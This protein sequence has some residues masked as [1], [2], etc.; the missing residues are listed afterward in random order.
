MEPCH[1]EARNR[2]YRTIVDRP[3]HTR[4]CEIIV[5]GARR[6]GAPTDGVAL[7]VGEDARRRTREHPL[8]ECG[9]IAG[10]LSLL[11]RSAR[12]PSRHVPAASTPAA[13]SEQRL[14]IHPPV[15]REPAKVERTVSGAR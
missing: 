11:I 1:E 12:K 10:A 5:F 15:A 8:L 4:S 13:F 7:Q 14:E 2:P 6:D 3:E 9:P